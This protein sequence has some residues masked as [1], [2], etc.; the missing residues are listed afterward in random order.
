M[1]SRLSIVSR[2]CS[3]A[4][5]R[6]LRAAKPLSMPESVL[7][8]KQSTQ[9]STVAGTRLQNGLQSAPP[10]TSACALIIFG[11]KTLYLIDS[12]LSTTLH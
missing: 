11:G 5:S 9:H 2:R 7:G 3:T 4:S 1:L 6:Y 12:L 8:C 10:V